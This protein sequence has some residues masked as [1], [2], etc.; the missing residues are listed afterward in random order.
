MS[1]H[2]KILYLRDVSQNETFIDLISATNKSY[3]RQI[4]DEAVFDCLTNSSKV[5]VFTWT[6]TKD[7]SFDQFGHRVPLS[8]DW[9]NGVIHLHKTG[10]H[11]EPIIAK[12]F[13][14]LLIGLLAEKYICM[15]L[16]FF[17]GVP[18][19]PASCSKLG[20][21]VLGKNRCSS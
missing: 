15:K 13:E 14:G 7:G 6:R 19:N 10:Q 9:S 21:K 20:T 12:E 4:A 8:N 2:Q 18:W 17:I 16:L 5:K 11:Y 1:C 3:A